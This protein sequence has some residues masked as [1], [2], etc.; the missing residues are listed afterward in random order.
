[1]PGSLSAVIRYVI[2]VIK[3]ISILVVLNQKS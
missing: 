3:A 1:M 2:G